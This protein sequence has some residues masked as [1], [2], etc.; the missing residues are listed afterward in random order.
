M[1]T[2]IVG[3]LGNSFADLGSLPSY[4]SQDTKT[5]LCEAL[6]VSADICGRLVCLRC[7]DYAGAATSET[8][9]S[10]RD[11]VSF[12]ICNKKWCK[13]P[14]I[15]SGAVQKRQEGKASAKIED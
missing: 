15:V 10:G 3:I 12:L 5:G 1:C 7:A 2:F 14:F 8:K 4:R 9:E 13:R 6:S 11:A